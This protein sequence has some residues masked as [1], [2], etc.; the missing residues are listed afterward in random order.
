MITH[1]LT[2]P[3]SPAGTTFAKDLSTDFWIVLPQRVDPKGEEKKKKASV[4]QKPSLAKLA[5]QLLNNC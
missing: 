4:V 3:A 1:V 5:K 2:P